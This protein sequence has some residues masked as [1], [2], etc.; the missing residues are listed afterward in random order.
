VETQTQ[1]R[2]EWFW[3]MVSYMKMRTLA[4]WLYYYP[5]TTLENFDLMW[6]LIFDRMLSQATARTVAELR[7]QVRIINN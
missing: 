5:C 4:V 3:M 6:P 7:S 1:A 2:D